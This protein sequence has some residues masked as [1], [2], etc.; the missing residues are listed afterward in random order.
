MPDYRMTAKEAEKLLLQ[1]GFIIDRQK[2]SHKIYVKGS[3]RQVL[4]HHSG[5]TLHPK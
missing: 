3:L 2:G 5:K 1:N 4:P